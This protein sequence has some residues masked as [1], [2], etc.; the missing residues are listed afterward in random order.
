MA[1]IVRRRYLGGAAAALGG[2]LA[3]AC[4]EPTVRYVGQPQAGPAGPA[5]PQGVKGA[6]GAQGAQ[7]AQGA[8][9]AA[10]KAPVTLDFQHR[11]N[12]PAR[13]PIVDEAIKRFEEANPGIFVDL[14]M[15][16]SRGDG[17]DGGVPIGKILAAIAAGTP[18]D[19][20]MIHAR[21]AI[22]FAQRNALSW[23]D[24]FLKKD[25]RSLEELYFPAVFPYIQYQG[26]TFALPQTAS[27]DNPYT[28][29][30]KKLLSDKGVDANDLNTWQGLLEAAK[31]LTDRQGDSFKQI[32]FRY[33]GAGFETWHTANGGQL[34]SPDGRKVLFN[35]ELGREALTYMTESVK[36][37]YGSW[38]SLDAFV[39]ANEV[40]I[41]A[42]VDSL[43]A[44]TKLAISMSGPWYWVS[45]P[46]LAPDLDMGALRMPRNATNG[47]SKQTTLAQSVWTW[48]MG[49]GLK[50]PDEA[51]LLQRWMSQ[52]EGHRHLMTTMGRATMYKPVVTDKIYYDNNPGWDLVL[53]TIQN[54]TPLP[55]SKGW[56][57]V[58][59]GIGGMAAPVLEG[60][61]GVSEVLDEA[62]RQGQAAVDKA[63][64]QAEG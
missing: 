60:K 39:K 42:P 13:E 32:G 29:Y 47:K 24:D 2:L 50:H 7:G 51:W 3:A 5:G 45:V 6:A 41:S 30:N 63:Y 12:G 18:P 31:T 59:K 25:G 37:V 19:S 27:G 34:L 54:A 53:E 33:P 55:I 4:G 46:Q 28:F 56:S 62:A 61:K 10:A 64:A 49:A 17:T 15:N 22:D 57:P 21:A 48:A 43:F 36:Q 23:L 38:L 20:F 26:K 35:D 11:W 9:G 16:L 58:I 52:D 1:G 44:N 14:T 40:E 8:A